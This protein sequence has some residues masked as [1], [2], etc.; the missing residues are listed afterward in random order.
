MDSL[1]FDDVIVWDNSVQEDRKTA[2]RYWPLLEANL[3]VVYFQDD[4]VF[5]PPDTQRR[6]VESYMPGVM[7]ANYGHG[8]TPDG[9]DDMPLLHAGAIV[10][11]GL[12]W[13]GLDRYLEFHPLDDDFLYE[14][15]FIAGILYDTFTHVHLPHEIVMEIAQHPSRMCNQPWQK[16]RKLKITNRARVIRDMVFA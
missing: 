15:D 13:I 6:I 11:S 3:G 4:D 1:I 16:E 12:P 5:V 10:D 8:E 9:Y 7:V 14:A 2:G